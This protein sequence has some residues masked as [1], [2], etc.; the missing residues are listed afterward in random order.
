MPSDWFSYSRL[1]VFDQCPAKYRFIHIEDRPA[2]GESIESFLGTRLHEALEW[3]YRE[4]RSGRNIL[5]DDLLKRYSALWMEAWHGRVNIVD[6]GWETDDY[7][8]QGQRCLAGYYRRHTPFDE[9]VHSTEQILTFDLG[10]RGGYLMKAILDRLDIHGPGW[11]SIHDYKSGRRM[12]TDAQA[13]KDLQMK[14]Y[15]LALARTR[16]KVERVDVVWHFLRHGQEVSLKHVGWNPMRIA[17]MLKKRIDRVRE[18]EAQPTL[19]QPQESLLC[20]WCYYWEVCPVKCGAE[21]PAR[22]AR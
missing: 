11:W 13:E 7:Y 17:T 18:Y 19:L 15:F 9:P 16:E 6:P 2:S 5:F 14:V 22:V 12:L 3:L 21:H 4:R 20:S 8:Q 1:Q 10:G